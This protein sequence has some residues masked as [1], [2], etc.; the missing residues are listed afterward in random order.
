MITAITGRLASISDRSAALRVGAL[1]YELLVP[2][3]DLQSLSSRLG[4][5]IT[6][7]TILYLEGDAARGNLE[8]RLIGFTNLRDKAFFEKFT[9]VK[10]IGV[11]TALRAL[12]IPAP[13]IAAAI[14]SHNARFLTQLPG[15]GKRTAELI[16]A[17]LS[18]KLSV[19]AVAAT[20]GEPLPPALRAL[21]PEEEDAIN[22]MVSLGERR[23]EVERLLQAVRQAFPQA[24]STSDLLRE[25]LRMR[26]T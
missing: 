23:H 15:I 7:H 16:I 4:E 13:Q 9:T 20:P 2:A 11:K 25:M 21:T 12:E 8:P 6:F 19:F 5:E 3:S 26:S 10:G 24:K 14:E 22:A 1:E 17:E 18:G